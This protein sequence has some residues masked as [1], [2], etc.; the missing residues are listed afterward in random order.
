MKKRFKEIRIFYGNEYVGHNYCRVEF[1]FD[2]NAFQNRLMKLSGDPRVHYSRS[3]TGEFVFDASVNSSDFIYALKRTDLSKNQGA[4]IYYE[5]CLLAQDYKNKGAGVNYYKD[6]DCL[7]S[8]EELI[9]VAS[10]IYFDDEE[11]AEM[12]KFKDKCLEVISIED[13]KIEEEK[14]Q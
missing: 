9:N 1:V 13:V 7:M 2:N 3:K 4:V 6:D 14:E 5:A 11:R 12:G 10:E 8:I